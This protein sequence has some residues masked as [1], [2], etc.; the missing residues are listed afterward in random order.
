[1]ATIFNAEPRCAA[2]PITSQGQASPS[3]AN[4]VKNYSLLDRAAEKNGG[5]K[6]D[7]SSMWHGTGISFLRPAPQASSRTAWAN[8][9]P[10][11][12]GLD[13]MTRAHD[14]GIQPG[15]PWNGVGAR[16]SR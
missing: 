13:D 2:S 15:R 9:K 7:V 1:V 14:T 5:S 6:P 11:L 12:D 16:Q 4:K 8:E 3:A 10:L